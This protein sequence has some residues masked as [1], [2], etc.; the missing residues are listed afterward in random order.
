VATDKSI[1]SALNL[2]SSISFQAK[3]EVEDIQ[4]GESDHPPS[5]YDAP[6]SS[7]D[8]RTALSLH[9]FRLGF[10]ISTALSHTVHSHNV[11]TLVSSP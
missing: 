6:E 10:A 8:P 4:G 7:S 11:T 9:D 5:Y 1:E 3:Y 2:I